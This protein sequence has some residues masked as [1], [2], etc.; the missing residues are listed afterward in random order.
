MDALA[1]LLSELHEFYVKTD[2]LILLTFEGQVEDGAVQIPQHAHDALNGKKAL[3]GVLWTPKEPA[4]QPSA[5]GSG[6]Q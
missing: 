2:S 5:N 3:V 1:R 4:P 6:T